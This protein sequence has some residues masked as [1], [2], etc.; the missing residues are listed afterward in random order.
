MTWLG[1]A[2]LDLVPRWLVAA[3][4]AHTPYNAHT[5]RLRI[6]FFSIQ[7]Y[8]RGPR[9]SRQTARAAAWAAARACS[10]WRTTHDGAERRVD[11]LHEVHWR[12]RGRR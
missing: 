7:A 6:R 11:E 8:A 2:Q 1:L 9:Y 3:F 4:N 10:L 5:G 12:R